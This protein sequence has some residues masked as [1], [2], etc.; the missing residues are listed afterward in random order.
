MYKGNGVESMA[1]MEGLEHICFASSKFSSPGFS[2]IFMVDDGSIGREEV[3]S[4]PTLLVI[5]I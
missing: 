4:C 3:W 5:E 2:W 1:G